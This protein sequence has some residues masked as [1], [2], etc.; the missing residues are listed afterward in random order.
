MPWQ[1]SKGPIDADARYFS[2]PKKNKLTIW[3]VLFSWRS[4]KLIMGLWRSVCYLFIYFFGKF[5]PDFEI[6]HQLQL[7]LLCSRSYPE[8]AVS[9]SVSAALI[10][11][12]V[13]RTTPEAALFVGFACGTISAILTFFF[14]CFQQE[15]MNESRKITSR[16]RLTH[17]V[18]KLLFWRREQRNQRHLARTAPKARTL[19]HNTQNIVHAIRGKEIE[20]LIFFL[21]MMAM[22]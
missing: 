3:I 14:F 4:L 1:S 9:P 19:W 13:Q 8:R 17:E 15:T 6:R 20:F 12:D 22:A 2:E 5:T 7:A 10:D 21:Y 16:T 11:L 18:E